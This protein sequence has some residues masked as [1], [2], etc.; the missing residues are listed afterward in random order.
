MRKGFAWAA[1]ILLM[2]ATA[3]AGAAQN[4]KRITVPAGTR[5]LIRMIDSID[6]TKQKAG[7]RFTASLE[8]NLQA[9]DVVVAPRG[10]TVYGKLVTAESAGKFK[11]SS[12]L[13]L[14]LTDIMIN[15]TAYPLLT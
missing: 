11:G 15:N 2:L 1:T 6:S 7:F 5:I 9:E 14:E 12:E 8:T 4:V 3:V 10:T 13:I